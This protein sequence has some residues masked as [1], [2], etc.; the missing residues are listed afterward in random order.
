MKNHLLAG[1]LIAALVMLTG[2]EKP[3][4]PT[5][6]QNTPPPEVNQNTPVSPAESPLAP[7]VLVTEGL[8]NPDSLEVG[9]AVGQ[10]APDIQ[11]PD[12]DGVEFKLSDYRGQVIMLDFYGDW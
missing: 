9:P 5:V 11:G 4:E 12:L 8:D 2:C 6:T 7:V 10:M 3:E 1:A